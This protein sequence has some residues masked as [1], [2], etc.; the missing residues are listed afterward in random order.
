M[1]KEKKITLA[2]SV[3]SF[4]RSIPIKHIYNDLTKWNSQKG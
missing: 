1:K 2:T 3:H 4:L